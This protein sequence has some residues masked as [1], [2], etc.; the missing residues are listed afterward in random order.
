MNKEL[1]I[2]LLPFPFCGGRNLR[3]QIERRNVPADAMGKA[4]RPGPSTMRRSGA[5][6]AGCFR[7]A[8]SGGT[9]EPG[10]S[11][12]GAG[13]QAAED[14]PTFTKKL[15]TTRLTARTADYPGPRLITRITGI[16]LRTPTR[17]ASHGPGAG[18]RRAATAAI[19]QDAC[20]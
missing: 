18:R 19:L 16:S 9:G 8:A 5:T 6:F 15:A 13:S 12:E 7:M 4:C 3:V 17:R 10:I 1:N 14:R 11:H 20:H 2:G